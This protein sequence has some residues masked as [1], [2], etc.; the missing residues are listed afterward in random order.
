MPKV[1]EKT[2]NSGR[3]ILPQGTEDTCN[4]ICSLIHTLFSIGV[5]G[6]AFDPGGNM[7]DLCRVLNPPLCKA[8]ISAASSATW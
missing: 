5:S 8:R 1:T 2:T 4:A 3:Y 7:A 6:V